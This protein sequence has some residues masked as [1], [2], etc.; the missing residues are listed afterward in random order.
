MT[1][2]QTGGELTGARISPPHP[3]G[4]WRK[5]ASEEI[6]SNDSSEHKNVLD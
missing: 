2:G 4:L 5:E 1:H 6:A 3:D